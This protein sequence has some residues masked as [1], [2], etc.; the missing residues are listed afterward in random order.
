MHS[1]TVLL[2]VLLV[3]VATASQPTEWTFHAHSNA[4]PSQRGAARLNY[5]NAPPAVPE[6][7]Y[8]FGGFDECFDVNVCE[9]TWYNEVWRYTFQDQSWTNMNP[10]ADPV[11]GLPGPRGFFSSAVYNSNGVAS[12]IY[13]GGGMYNA[14]VSVRQW[15]DDVWEYTPSTN[16]WRKRIPTN[17]G[18][19]ARLGPAIGIFQNKFYAFGGINTA[20]QFQNDFWSFDLVSNTWVQIGATNAAD[21]TLPPASYGPQLQLD[22]NAYGNQLREMIIFGGNIFPPG[23]G[24][25]SEQTWI[26]DFDTALWR[27][28]IST[29]PV[30]GNN[31][32]RTHGASCFKHKKFIITQG[33]KDDPNSECRT[34]QASGGQLTTNGTWVLDTD[35]NTWTEVE[36]TQGPKLKRVA[37]A[38]SDDRSLYIWGG[39]DFS[40][41]NGQN[42]VT[43]NTDLYSLDIHSI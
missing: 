20:F 34:N 9:H 16:S 36:T 23:S 35:S 17:T 8:V 15:Y 40:C 27:K 30:P 1:Y 3:G 31:V 41:V 10:A 32:G 42:V 25:Q 29:P 14:R 39:F 43:W 21:P 4:P 18:P 5:I 11:Y 6:S 13:F 12:I 2:S 37:F 26:Y 28:V 22:T 7:L 33:D 19:S 24:A 38:E